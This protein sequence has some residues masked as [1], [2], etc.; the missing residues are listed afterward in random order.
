MDIVKNITEITAKIRS[1]NKDAELVAATKTRTIDEVRLAFNTGLISAAGENR[2]QEL[3][4]KFDAAIV[5]DFIG[6]LQTNKVKYI[7]DKARLIHSVDRLELAKVIDKEAKKINKI[8]DCLI[9]VNSG[10]ED[11][12]G[13]IYLEDVERF[14]D[15]IAPFE[16]IRIRGIMAV[17]PLYYTEDELRRT[18]DEVY[19]KY[20][21]FKGGCFNYL[22]MGMSNDYLVAVEAGANLVRLGRAIFGERGAFNG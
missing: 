18:F 21:L 22:S 5:W 19:A 8:Q 4:S 11:T 14:L 7:I 3:I 10:K 16:N 1:I 13:G 20:T 6:Q 12:K 9:E 15:E 17:A 2:A